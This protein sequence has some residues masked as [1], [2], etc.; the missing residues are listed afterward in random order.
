MH[1]SNSSHFSFL[2]QLTMIDITRTNEN[3]LESSIV[4]RK[5]NDTYDGLME[6]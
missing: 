4:K 1:I 2:S 6:S 3:S 5:K